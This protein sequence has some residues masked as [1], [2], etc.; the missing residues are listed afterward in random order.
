M[1]R[2]D[3][4]KLSRL[5]CTAKQ[6]DL[7]ALAD[8]YEA[9][10]SVMTRWVNQR[11][12]GAIR[13]KFGASDVFQSAYR[14]VQRGFADFRGQSSLEFVA[15]IRTI[16]SRNLSNRLR[17]FRPGSF[18]DIGIEIPLW[19]SNAQRLP[20]GIASP[21]KIA[22]ANE[23][24]DKLAQALAKLSDADRQ[25]ILWRN[26]DRLAFASIGEK[27]NCSAEA[28]RKRWSRILVHLQKLMENPDAVGD[29]LP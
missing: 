24:K 17:P 23:E 28:A 27:L 9:C 15:W 11:L 16:I 26:Y 6:G 8:G 4:G 13:G 22:V 20:G 12:H 14:D 25:I 21:S 7:S 18:Q 19:E 10:R 29:S 5:L 1:T 3:S 2:I